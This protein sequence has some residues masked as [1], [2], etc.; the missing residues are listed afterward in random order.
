MSQP[1]TRVFDLLDQSLAKH[2][3]SDVFASKINGDWQRISAKD[4]I[5]S[6]T[7]LSLG[8][9]KMGVEKGDKIAVISESRPEWNIVDFAVQQVGAIGVPLYPNITVDDYRYIFNDANIKLIFVGD[10]DLLRKVQDAA[11]DAQSVKKFIL[12]IKLKEIIIGKKF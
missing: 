8:F 2:N 3:K 5:D 4:F 1:I 11:K 7:Q 12:S 10:V 9:F 6:V